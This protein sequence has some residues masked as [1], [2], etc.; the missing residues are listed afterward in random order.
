[1]YK[2]RIPLLFQRFNIEVDILF[3]FISEFIVVAAKRVLATS[4]GKVKVDALRPVSPPHT[5]V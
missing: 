1:L 3:S 2:P 5:N 4:N